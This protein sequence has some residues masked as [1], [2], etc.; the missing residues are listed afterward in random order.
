MEV[1]FYNHSKRQNSLKLP[2]GGV[3]I[4]CVLKSE[5]SIVAPIL[6]LRLESVPTWNYCYISDFARYYYVTDWKYD[7]GIWTAILSVDVLTSWRDN[8]L[9]TT[10][11]VEFS[12]SNFSLHNTDNRVVASNT[13]SIAKQSIPNELSVFDAT[14]CYILSVISTDANGYNGACAVYALTQ[15]LLKQFSEKI[16]SQ[17]FLDGLW[18]SLKNMFANP[19][20]AIVSCRWVPFS[21]GSLSGEDAEITLT[22]VKTG[23]IG[24]LLSSNFKGQSVTMN[25]PRLESSPTFLDTGT[26]VT[27]TLY[28]PFV[29]VVPLDVDAYYKSDTFSI[30]MNCDVVTG[31]IVYTIG[32]SYTDFTSTYSGNCATTV[33]LSHN[34]MD[35]LGASAGSAGIIGGIVSTVATLVTKKPVKASAL[36]R[37]SKTIR[38]S[39]LAT[40]AS[41]LATIRSAEVHTH[42][43]GALSSRIGSKISLTFELV[44]IRSTVLDN[45]RSPERIATVGLPCYR[46]LKLSTLSGFCKCNGACVTAPATDSELEE[47]DEAVNNGIYIE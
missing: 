17:N 32:T 40:G 41:A 44:T 2:S 12:S 28:L 5:T 13:K 8:I 1:V 24:K 36:A 3:N 4:P 7:R 20:E 38:N 9:N 16:T 42:T 30:K 43:N 35:T 25:L 23:V 15:P 27:A 31:D 26:F 34:T 18:E 21:W 11:F 6:E 47:M 29:G 10:A 19:F 37:R 22:Y 33:P 45:V 14:G 46:T 39:L